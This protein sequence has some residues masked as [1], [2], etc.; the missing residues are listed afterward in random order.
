VV[1]SV[2]SAF[3]KRKPKAEGLFLSPRK[4]N[5]STDNS[6][7]RNGKLMFSKSRNQRDAEFTCVF[8]FI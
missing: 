4:I 1:V 2:V 7:K 6:V 8:V 3:Y 5:K